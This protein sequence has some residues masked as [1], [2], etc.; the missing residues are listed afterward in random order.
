MGW[1]TDRGFDR[2]HPDPA[3]RE[4]GTAFAPDV[5]VLMIHDLP[6]D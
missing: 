4:E 1:A 6:T 3:M 2:P 5:K